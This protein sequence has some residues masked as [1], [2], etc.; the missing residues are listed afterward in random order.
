MEHDSSKPKSG[1]HLC[2]INTNYVTG[3]AILD[4]FR[5]M[6]YVRC[7]NIYVIS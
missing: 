3:N 1:V 2:N 4:V 5:K 6:F 7:Q